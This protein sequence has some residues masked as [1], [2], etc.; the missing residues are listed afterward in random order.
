MYF[1][2]YVMII[3]SQLF[4]LHIYSYCCYIFNWF[5]NYLLTQTKYNQNQFMKPQVMNHPVIILI[6][7][8]KIYQNQKAKCSIQ[9][10]IRIVEFFEDSSFQHFSGPKI[11]ILRSEFRVGWQKFNWKQDVRFSRIFDVISSASLLSNS[12]LLF[13]FS[14][15]TSSRT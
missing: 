10:Q 11:K 14:S 5:S 6:L 1:F 12:L 8:T 9:F 3:F 7:M 4:L 2:N 15:Q 13:T